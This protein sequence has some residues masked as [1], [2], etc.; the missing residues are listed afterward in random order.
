MSKS[1]DKSVGEKLHFKVRLGECDDTPGTQQVLSK[2]Q[3]PKG[4]RE[5][6][7]VIYTGGEAGHLWFEGQNIFEMLSPI[8]FLHSFCYFKEESRFWSFLPQ[9]TI[10]AAAWKSQCL[11]GPAP[12]CRY[13]PGCSVGGGGGGAGRH[14]GVVCGPTSWRGGREMHAEAW[15][16]WALRSCGSCMPPA[17]GTLRAWKIILSEAPRHRTL[18]WSFHDLGGSEQEVGG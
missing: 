12:S 13:C 15:R 9:K 18:K 4:M 8:F 7:D 10:E 3:L 17:S 11:E 2:C 1:A 14:K 5:Q 16:S 6:V